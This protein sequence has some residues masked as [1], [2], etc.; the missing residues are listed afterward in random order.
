[1]LF[2]VTLNDLINIIFIAVGVG[3]CALCLLQITVS[4]HLR[5][6]IK[7][8]F[9][10]F[11]FLIILYIGTHL[12]RMIFD[13]MP[14][15]GNVDWHKII[16]MLKR[17]PRLMVVQSEVCLMPRYSVKQLC[18]PVSPAHLIKRR[19]RLDLPA[20]GIFAKEAYIFREHVETFRDRRHPKV[21][22]IPG[23]CQLVNGPHHPIKGRLSAGNRTLKVL[24]LRRPVH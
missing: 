16:P 22:G 20:A 3:V 1:M 14:G 4:N 19:F 17:A 23:F 11:F 10:V 5:K 6:E 21:E 13:S 8:Y 12:L 9:Q 7:R 18:A 2:E 24:R 15:E